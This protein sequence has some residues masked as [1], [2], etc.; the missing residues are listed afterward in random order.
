[1]G[2]CGADFKSGARAVEVFDGP[3]VTVE[4]FARGFLGPQAIWLGP[5]TWVRGFAS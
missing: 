4:L 3:F 5:F 2:D 1:M